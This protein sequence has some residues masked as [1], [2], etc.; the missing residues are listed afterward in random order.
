MAATSMR[1]VTENGTRLDQLRSLALVI[2]ADIDRGDE[3]HSMAQLARQYRETIREIAE[4][5]G[6]DGDNDEIAA[7][8]SGRATQGRTT[9]D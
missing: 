5:E 6:E 4:L 7:I 1:E 2:A 3:G 9:A 8:I